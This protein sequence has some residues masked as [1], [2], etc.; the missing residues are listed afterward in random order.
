LKKSIQSVLSQTYEDLDIVVVD[1]GSHDQEEVRR[2]VEEHDDERIRFIPL[3]KNSGKW[4][5]LNSAFSTTR[6]EFCTSHDADDVSL[7]WRI[8]AQLSA[9]LETKTAHNLCGFI[10]C[11]N[12]EEMKAAEELKTE[13]GQ[14]KIVTSEEVTSLVLKGFETPGI[15]HYFTGGFETAGVSAFFH[16][17]I[18]DWGFRFLPPGMNLRTL[19]S[20]DSDFNFRVTAGLRSTSILMEKPY[21]YRRN[22]STNKEER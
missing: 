17:K 19:L 5:A 14:L 22:T 11:W 18:W 13:P 7:S 10:S 8:S 16:K 1:D 4:N 3:S 21:L 15:N 20:E 12:E 2:I 6:A 9:L